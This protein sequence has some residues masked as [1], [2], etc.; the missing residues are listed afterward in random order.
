MAEYYERSENMKL[1]YDCIRDVLLFL[2]NSPYNETILFSSIKEAFPKYSE[3]VLSYT[4]IK[5]RE[6][7]MIDGRFVNINSSNM[8]IVHSITDIT[9]TGHEFLSEIHED[10]VW[11]GVKSVAGKIGVTSISALT[12]IAS[13]VVTELIKS[14]FGLSI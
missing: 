13:S 7:N 4:C 9:I 14:Q 2:E 5:L 10:T 3:D 8:P 1:N 11:N 12:Q 6:A